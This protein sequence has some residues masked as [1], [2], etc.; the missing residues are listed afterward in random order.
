MKKMITLIVGVGALG[1]ATAHA[2]TSPVPVMPVAPEAPYAPAPGLGQPAP[3]DYPRPAGMP[4]VVVP[5]SGGPADTL[6]AGP[7]AYAPWM[8]RLGSAVLVGGGY[9]DFTHSAPR[10]MTGAG[11]FWTARLVGGTRQLIGLEA[12]YIGAARSVDTFGL[13]SSS[14]LISNGFEGALRL[15]L[16][17]VQGLSLVEPFGFVGLG[18]QHYTV[19]NAGGNTSN[20]VGTSDDVMTMP[21]G[22]GLEVAYAR[23]IADARV[24]YRQTYFNDMLRTTGGNLNTWD[25]G[26][27]VGVEF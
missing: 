3:P 15:N 20:L 12:A 1:A 23:F 16:P 19:T 10:N 8:S 21:Y 17:I 18:W 24:T 11:G 5:V 9:E 14:D 7:P 26:A 2:Q 22:A 13:P 25:V 6:A 4:P 27:Q